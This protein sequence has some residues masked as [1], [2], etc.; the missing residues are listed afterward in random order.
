MSVKLGPFARNGPRS[1]IEREVL[2]SLQ[3]C[4]FRIEPSP[5]GRHARSGWLARKAKDKSRRFS[6]KIE[7][8]RSLSIIPP[9][10]ARRVLSHTTCRRWTRSLDSEMMPQIKPEDRHCL[11]E[12][13][14][15]MLPLYR[16]DYTIPARL[17]KAAPEMVG[18]IVTI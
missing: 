15:E 13:R 3:P 9:G 4:G 6:L 8:R 10:L 17:S 5:D 14:L 18:L 16:R 12:Y 1:E 7:A 11:E 2:P